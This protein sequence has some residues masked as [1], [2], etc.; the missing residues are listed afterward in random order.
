V[1]NWI[2][3]EEV[4][5]EVADMSPE[6]R[7]EVPKTLTTPGEIADLVVELVETESLAGRVVIWWTTTG[8]ELVPVEKRRK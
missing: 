4:L 2:A 3:T 8:P 6:E 5:G 7:K 1:P